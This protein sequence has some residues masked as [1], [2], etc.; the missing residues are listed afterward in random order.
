MNTN[1]SDNT[2]EKSKVCSGGSRFE[3]PFEEV[4]EIIIKKSPSGFAE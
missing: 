3:S 4:P 2:G 1:H